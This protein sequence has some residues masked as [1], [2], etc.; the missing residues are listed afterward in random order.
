M[1]LWRRS[2][3]NDN[4]KWWV[5]CTVAISTLLAGLDMSILV[6]CFP[7][8]ARSFG[9]DASVIAWI[10]VIYLLLSQSLMLTFA[11]FGDA[12][13]RK[14]V[15]LA[16]LACYFVGLVVCSMSRDVSHLIIGRAVQGIGA[17]AVFSLTIAMAVAVFPGDERG[18]ALGLLT[19]I[20]SVG[21]MAGPLMGGIIMD[22]LGWRAIFYIRLPVALSALGMGWLV[23]KEPKMADPLFRLDII[24]SAYLFSSLTCLLLFLSFGGSQ[25]FLT[26]LV[27]ALGVLTV[28]FSIQFLRAEKRCPQPV[29]DLSLFR[30]PLFSAATASAALHGA[31]TVAVVFLAPFY[32]TEGLGYSALTTGLFMAIL[33]APPFIVGPLSGRLSD[34]IGS[35]LLTTA[36][37]CVSCAAILLLRQ[38]GAQP[39]HL[40]IGLSL[41]LVGAGMGIFMPP[42]NSAIMG[43]VA[44]D[45][46]GT[47]SAIASTALQLGLSAGAAIAGTVF[48]RRQLFHVAALSHQGLALPLMEKTAV[49]NSFKDALI[50]SILFCLAG[51]A[52]SSV[53][54]SSPRRG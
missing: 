39:T 10:N 34:R 4:Y 27:P 31:G 54:G 22:L 9:T 29:I 51:I 33:A 36:G 40:A 7:A 15:Y 8:L 11:R 46:L 47:A 12:R 3:K 21:L 26:S 35:R 48:G 5:L 14:R 23:I 20:R 30:K 6:V 16:G 50:V 44:K 45:S 17:A 19:G 28:I 42:N 41:A 52:A 18:K 1:V 37:L 53:R 24:G 43:S 49:I 38:L 13:G 2:L 32:L 25:G